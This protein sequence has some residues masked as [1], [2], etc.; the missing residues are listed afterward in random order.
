[1]N[2]T[3]RESGVFHF[4]K[5]FLLSHFFHNHPYV[6]YLISDFQICYY[7]FS[8][9]SFMVAET[10]SLETLNVIKDFR[11]LKV[12]LYMLHLSDMLKQTPQNYRLHDVLTV[13]WR[14]CLFI[15][16]LGASIFKV[17]VS[18][19]SVEKTY[20][21]LL[22]HQLVKVWRIKK[23]WEVFFVYWLSYSLTLSLRKCIIFSERL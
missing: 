13:G 20:C 18:G 6:F 15:Y 2:R 12:C 4:S 16:E 14:Y 8:S 5:S 23:E 11:S 9:Q 22:L 17:G 1:M 10:N 21:A 3:V 7:N 19:T